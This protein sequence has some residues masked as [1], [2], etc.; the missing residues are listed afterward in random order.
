MRQKERFLES[1]A[2]GPPPECPAGPKSPRDRHA[3][4]SLCTTDAR[5]LAIEIHGIAIYCS[6]H[7]VSFATA[8][9]CVPLPPAPFPFGRRSQEGH[10]GRQG[11][12]RRQGEGEVIGAAWVW[13][14]CRDFLAEDGEIRFMPFFSRCWWLAPSHASPFHSLSLFTVVG[15]VA[16]GLGEG[17][18]LTLTW[19]SSCF[20]G[21]GEKGMQERSGVGVP[22]RALQRQPC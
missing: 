11:Q 17:K 10:V 16:R 3:G 9:P 2:P 6:P 19:L 12:R 4:V 18:E 1:E 7:P 20:Q 5:D 13:A 15:K 8:G 22:G 21:R 14:D